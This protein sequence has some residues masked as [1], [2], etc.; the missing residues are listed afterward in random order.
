MSETAVGPEHFVERIRSEVVRAGGATDSAF[1]LLEDGLQN[2]PLSVALWC[3]R[4]D[5]IQLAGEDG[6]HTF[7]E[8]EASYLRAAELAPTDPEPIESLGHFYD[9]VMDDPLRAEPYFR[10]AIAL[11]A[12]ASAQEGLAQVL[13]ELAEGEVE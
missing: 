1:R 6:P 5:V 13:E 11:G 8:A 7:D 2:H 3:L 12:G 10:R 4:G 9:D